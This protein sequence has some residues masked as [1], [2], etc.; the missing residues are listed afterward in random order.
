MSGFSLAPQVWDTHHLVCA[1]QISGGMRAVLFLTFW[2]QVWTTVSG[3]PTGAP[4]ARCVDMKPGHD[5]SAQSGSSPYTIMVSNTTFSTNQTIKVMIHGPVYI[6]LLLQ[7]RSGS[8]TDAVGTWGTPPSNTQYLTCSGIS[9]SAITHS[10]KNSKNSEIYTWIPPASL[11]S[12]FITATVVANKSTFW[13][14]LRSDTLRRDGSSNT[15]AD[16]RM[17][18]TPVLLLP[19]LMSVV[20]QYF[21]T[22]S[23]AH[24]P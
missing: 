17:A 12:A 11:D 15:A 18:V 19:L 20:L 8:S 22:D 6:G 13:I 5:V 2:L 3:F 24:A 9:Q 23:S 21:V 4:S 7:A 16:H 14:N 1:F 10:N